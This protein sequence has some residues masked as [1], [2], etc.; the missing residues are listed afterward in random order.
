MKKVK[1]KILTKMGYLALCIELEEILP[2]IV[3]I[4][5][6]TRKDIVERIVIKSEDIENE[7]FD[8]LLYEIYL[9]DT[10][11]SNFFVPFDNYEKKLQM[12]E[13]L[14]AD[15]EKYPRNKLMQTEKDRIKKIGSVELQNDLNKQSVA[16]QFLEK[17]NI[18]EKVSNEPT[19]EIK[20]ERKIEP[21][22]V[23]NH[24]SVATEER[25]A[26]SFI[27]DFL[28]VT[29]TKEKEP[30]H[31][32]VKESEEIKETIP[33]E[34]S[35]PEPLPTPPR[36]RGN[37]KIPLTVEN[38]RK[39]YLEENQSISQCS[40]TMGVPK[41]TLNKFVSDHPELKKKNKNRE[42]SDDS[43]EDQIPSIG[44][45]G[46]KVPTKEGGS[47]DERFKT[48]SFKTLQGSSETKD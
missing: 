14:K 43:K 11:K 5:K 15:E 2:C 17:L 29:V 40:E 39:Y 44:K 34:E 26:D 16:S 6:E 46:R 45:Y 18:D 42:S 12:A 47:Y 25:T 9:L 41:A 19:I 20:E 13:A 36:K 32:E 8:K 35:H 10:E 48:N 38:V 30:E 27:N 37:Y 21:L 22:S 28:N 33:T 23:E 31:E 4:T 3:I 1:Y 7:T 24:Q